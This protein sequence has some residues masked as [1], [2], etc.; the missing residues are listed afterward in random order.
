M[1]RNN[2]IVDTVFAVNM[3]RKKIN[4]IMS[5][6]M[7]ILIVCGEYCPAW[8]IYYLIWLGQ[9][10]YTDYITGY[11][12]N[13][14]TVSGM[15]PLLFSG[16]LLCRLYVCNH[17]FAGY[18]YS[19]IIMV[20][21]VMLCF[22]CILGRLSCMG[23]GDVDVFMISAGVNTVCFL[24]C[25]IDRMFYMI[26]WNCCFIYL[27]VFIFIILHFNKIIW[28]KMRLNHS[29]PMLPSVYASAVIFGIFI[30]TI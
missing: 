8:Y 3:I 24:Y 25:G 5:I 7:I 19:Y 4:Y 14:M 15:I 6:L 16:I 12:Y 17:H 1:K 29:Y 10:A 28:K 27:S 21:L 9:L 23:G 26:L 2:Y 13:R 11:V 30:F 18:N 20:I 22:I